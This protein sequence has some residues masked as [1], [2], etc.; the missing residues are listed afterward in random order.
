MYFFVTACHLVLPF[1]PHTPSLGRTVVHLFCSLILLLSNLALACCS[2]RRSLRVFPPHTHGF[3]FLT[4]SASVLPICLFSVHTTLYKM[5]LNFLSNKELVVGGVLRHLTLIAVISLSSSP[6][7]RCT[8]ARYLHRLHQHRFVKPGHAMIHGS[9]TYL[10][11][12]SPT[13]PM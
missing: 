1:P 4:F 12:L 13:R 8:R 6:Q 3:F 11:N 10:Q 5:S 2:P 7:C 9:E